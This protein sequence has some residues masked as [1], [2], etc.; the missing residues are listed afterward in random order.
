MRK[1]HSSSLTSISQPF[2]RFIGSGN[3]KNYRINQAINFI[4]SQLI[5]S[6]EHQILEKYYILG[7]HQILEN[8]QVL[9]E[10]LI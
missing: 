1:S 8:Y 2:K 9:D 5:I 10:N 6:D 7:E 4:E 3:Q